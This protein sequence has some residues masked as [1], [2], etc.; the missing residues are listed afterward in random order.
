MHPLGI[1][2][3]SKTNMLISP[4]KHVRHSSTYTCC[5]C[6]AAMVRNNSFSYF[7]QCYRAHYVIKMFILWF[8]QRRFW[9]LCRH[10]VCM[11][12][13]R[14]CVCIIHHYVCIQTYMRIRT[15]AAVA[16][17]TVFVI[18]LRGCL[19]LARRTCGLIIFRRVSKICEKRLLSPFCPSDS[20][21]TD[22]D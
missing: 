22:F 4:L 11:Y 2:K 7:V 18:W 14:E 8:L 16:T 10:H 21:W 13:V 5:L 19:E 15:H 20:H 9:Y 1:C 6:W 17:R 12:R 3:I